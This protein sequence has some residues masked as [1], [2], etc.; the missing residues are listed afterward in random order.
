MSQ[1]LSA[2]TYAT[3]VKAVHDGFGKHTRVL[4]EAQQGAIE[5]VSDPISRSTMTSNGAEQSRRTS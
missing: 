5:K 3:F 4:T 2:A 1:V